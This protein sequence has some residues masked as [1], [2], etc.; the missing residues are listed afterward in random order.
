MQRVHARDE[1]L[2]VFDP[3]VRD[4]LGFTAAAERERV[5]RQ[6]RLSHVVKVSHDDIGLLYPGRDY[7][8]VAA[9]WHRL[10]SGVVVVT[11]GPAGVYALWAGGEEITLPA[12]PTEV[13]DTV[14]AGDAFAA[15]L[16]DGLAGEVPP[17]AAAARGLAQVGTGAARRLLW[18]ASVSAAYTCGRPG[19]ES[20]DAAALAAALAS[21]GPAPAAD[22][23]RPRP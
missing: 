17:G 11:L 22:P 8:E 10:T 6:L 12:A 23:G 13:V 5:E 19:A 21:A 1:A 18:R 16:L 4:S 15:A 9:G 20:A 7:R 14:G 2:V 3:N